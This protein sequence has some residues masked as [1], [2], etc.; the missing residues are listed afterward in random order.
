MTMN[1]CTYAG[2][3]VCMNASVSV[4][5]Y[6]CLRILNRR[7]RTCCFLPTKF[8]TKKFWFH[9]IFQVSDRTDR[10]T[11]RQT[12]RQTDRQTE[13]QIDR[14]TVRHTFTQTDRQT[15]RRTDRQTDRQTDRRTDGR[16]D[17]QTD[18]R[19]KYVLGLP[20]FKKLSSEYSNLI[21]FFLRQQYI[22]RG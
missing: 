3:Y 7:R 11:V 6:L 20:C 5:M 13:R 15:D 14:Q 2:M 18:R 16:T 8:L 22:I 10:Q 1:I 4:C 12:V 19:N 21:D 17:R 9:Q